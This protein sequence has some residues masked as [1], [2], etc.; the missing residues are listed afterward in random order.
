MR[1]AIFPVLGDVRLDA[2]EKDR[3]SEPFNLSS[4]TKSRSLSGGQ[5]RASTVDFEIRRVGI[6]SS[7]GKQFGK[8][9][10]SNVRNEPETRGMLSRLAIQEN[11]I[12]STTVKVQE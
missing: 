4:Q 12:K 10:M 1:A 2:A 9:A 7:P 11:A 8:Q 3:N 5:K 6:Q